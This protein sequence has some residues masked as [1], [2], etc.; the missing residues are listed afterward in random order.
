MI[1]R[2]Y[3]VIDV[4]DESVVEEVKSVINQIGP[5][6]SFSPS[7]EQP[8]LAHCLD[9]FGTA[10]DI[11]MEEIELLLTKLNNDWDGEMDDCDAY[12]FNTKMFHPRVYYLQFQ[13]Q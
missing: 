2:L 11:S 3:T 6:F 13:I 1:A 7:R 5:K 12:G 4:E 10:E 8:T 9:F